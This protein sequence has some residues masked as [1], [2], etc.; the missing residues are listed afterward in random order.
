EVRRQHDPQLARQVLVLLAALATVHLG[1]HQID[2]GLGDA[3][4]VRHDV[5]LALQLVAQRTELLER[6]RAGVHVHHDP[7][8]TGG[9]TAS[10]SAAPM[11]SDGSAGS[12]FT[13]TL[14]VPST[15]SNF[16]PYRSLAA[17]STSPTVS[18]GMSSRPV[19]AASRA[20]AKR[21]TM[22]IGDS[23]VV[24]LLSVRMPTGTSTVLLLR[25]GQSEWNAV[26]RWQGTADPPLTALGRRQARATADGLQRLDVSFTGVWASDLQR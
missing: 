10:S 6:E 19:P 21:R 18:P 8:D 13:H 22:A 7:P 14:H 23:V 3:P 1:A 4:H 25:H 20:A 2:A 11:L 24:P 15:S 26:R 12:P 16:G 9:S 17:A 5:V